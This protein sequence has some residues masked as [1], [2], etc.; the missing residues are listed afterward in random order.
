[1]INQSI[2]KNFT[3]TVGVDAGVLRYLLHYFLKAQKPHK[4][5]TCNMGVTK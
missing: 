4:V 3:G 1:M 5:E 2:A